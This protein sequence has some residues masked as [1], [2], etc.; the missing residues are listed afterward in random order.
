[1]TRLSGY[2]HGRVEVDGEVHTEDLMVTPSGVHAGWWRDGGHGVLVSD[3]AAILD[4][5]PEVFVFGTGSTGRMEP[6]PEAMKALRTAGI[7]VEVHLTAR[8]VERFNE[9]S[10]AGREVGAGL[11]LTC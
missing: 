11:H 5:P 7:E 3:V 10:D 4:D 6:S 2:R 1:M 8:A 9:I